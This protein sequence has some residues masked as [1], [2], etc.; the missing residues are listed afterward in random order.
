MG[1]FKPFVLAI[2][3][4]PFVSSGFVTPIL[5]NHLPPTKAL[6]FPNEVNDK[7]KQPLDMSRSNGDKKEDWRSEFEK[8]IFGLPSCRRNPESSRSPIPLSVR[9]FCS[10][11][12]SI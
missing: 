3:S 8:I 4:L 6:C 10:S 12:H 7:V 9:E 5:Q 2:C 1:I 11:F